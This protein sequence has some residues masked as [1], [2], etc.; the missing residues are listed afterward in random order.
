MSLQQ[1]LLQKAYGNWLDE[2]KGSFLVVAVI[3]HLLGVAL[4]FASIILCIWFTWWWKM[5]IISIASYV[6]AALILS[7]YNS[8]YMDEFLASRR[9]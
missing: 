4:I 2:N 1:Q 6:I 3:I 9:K 5:L 7:L 8:M